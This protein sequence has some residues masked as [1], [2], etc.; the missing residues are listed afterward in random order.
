MDQFM[1][2][3]GSAG[4]RATGDRQ[5]GRHQKRDRTFMSHQT[6]NIT[7]NNSNRGVV[8]VAHSG[9]ALGDSVQ[10][11]LDIR[12]RASDD[13][14]DFTRRCLLLQRL[15]EFLKQTDIL[16]RNHRLI[17]EGFEKLDLCRGEGAHFNAT[18]DQNSNEVPLLA[19]RHEQK[20]ASVGLRAQIWKI[21]LGL[22][23]RHVERAVLDHPAKMWLINT[24]LTELG[25]HGTKMGAQ[26]NHGPFAESQGQIL[27]PTNP[28]RAFD[29]GVEDRLHICRRAADDSENLGRGRLMLQG[30]SQ[31]CIA[32]LKF[33]EKSYVL[34]GDYGLVSKSLE[35]R[36]L[37]L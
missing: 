14:Q 10:H 7:L 22:D 3:N 28:R 20:G 36:D 8:C 4:N 27:D 25:W 23:V 6:K 13:S 24:Y 15:L 33:F 2:D 19:K 9:G 17:S 12:G 29:D 1:I 31:L 30:L 34:D 35:Q 26:N 32:L 18:R 21:S 37:L 16:Y 5:L 11:R